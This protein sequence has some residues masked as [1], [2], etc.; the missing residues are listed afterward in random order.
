MRR[1][2]FQA[3]PS[4]LRNKM[5]AV[6][7]ISQEASVPQESQ[8]ASVPSTSQRRNPP[9]IVGFNGPGSRANSGDSWP[10]EKE[11]S[12]QGANRVPPPST[13]ASQWRGEDVT[14]SIALQL[15]RA[16]QMLN[17][18]VANP[19]ST[20]YKMQRKKVTEMLDRAEKHMIYD[21]VSTFYEELLVEEMIQAE[22]D[23]STKDDELDLA[24]QKK[25]KVEGDKEDLLA[26]LPRGLGQRFSG[27]AADWTAF[28][29]YFEEINESV[30]PPLAV[31]HMTALIGCPK[32]RKRMKIYRSGDEVLKDFDKDY[33]FSFLNCAT[34][35][36]E[37]NGLK[38]ATTKSEEIDLI[39]KFRHAKRALDKNGDHE[40]LLNLS[41]LIRW[42]DQLLPTTCESLMGI[43]QEFKFGERGSAVEEYFRH[44][45]QVYERSSILLRSRSARKAPHMTNQPKPGGK[46]VDWVE[47]D[48]RAY[49]NEEAGADQAEDGSD[50]DTEEISSHERS[51]SE[52]DSGEDRSE[53]SSH[54]RGSDGENGSGEDRSENSSHESNSDGEGDSDEDGDEISSHQR[55]DGESG[56][57]ED[58]SETSSHE[59]DSDVEGDSDGNRA[60]SKTKEAE[61]T[62]LRTWECPRCKNLNSASWIKCNGIAQG[63]EAD[64]CLLARPCYEKYRV[65]QIKSK[66]TNRDGDWNCFYCGNINFQFRIE[67]NQCKL[68][69]NDAQSDKFRLLE[70][71]E[72]RS[73]P[74]EGFTDNSDE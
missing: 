62:K 37:I 15:Q 13:T 33:G 38:R 45:E 66:R 52:N 16:R 48:Q 73:G 17:V 64:V 74:G 1:G 6:R 61:L 68:P 72:T 39:I 70:E 12:D 5:A 21:Q 2:G 8:G 10:G 24:E 65:T 44:L 23:C 60:P 25:K 53:I 29:H 58:R 19:E 46:K 67:C 26:T 43:I 22:M 51:D 4:I 56:S 57:D 34:I 59:S 11:E 71:N 63:G 31:A 42:A 14:H 30:S 36:S 50:G 41:T 18:M 9:S 35:I 54:E 20:K 69:K 40:R 7:M 27:S 32:L 49:A 47:S 28:R 55:S 3:T